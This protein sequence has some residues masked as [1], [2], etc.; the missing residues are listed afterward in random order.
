MKSIKSLDGDKGYTGEEL[1]RVVVE[2][3]HAEDRIK[4]K[5]LDVPIWRTEGY[6]LKQAKRRKLR[7]NYRS[8]CETFHSVLK[9]RTGSAVRA[10]TVRMQNKEVSF[11]VLA[12]SVLRR[13][14]SSLFR[15][16]FY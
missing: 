10:V 9:R 16:L 1:R 8:L 3:C 2:E 12:C 13:T 6:Y 11:K 14:L 15:E 4:V 7:A 5:N